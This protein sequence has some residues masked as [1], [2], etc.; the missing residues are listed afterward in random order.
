MRAIGRFLAELVGVFLAGV[1]GFFTMRLLIAGAVLAWLIGC[2]SGLFL[3]VALAESAWW[4]HTHS[5]HTAV[6]AL[7]YYGYAACTFALIA[8]LFF[9][10]DKLTGWPERRRQQVAMCRIGGLRLAPDAPFEPPQ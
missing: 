5:H 8:V 9:L 6:T 1:L 4:L 7:G 10:K 2:V 3:L